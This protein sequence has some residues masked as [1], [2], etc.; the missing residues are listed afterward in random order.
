MDEDLLTF[1]G[2]GRLRKIDPRDRQY[3]LPPG[4]AV[5]QPTAKAYQHWPA[6]RALDQGNSSSCVG[7]ACHALLRCSP[8]RNSKNIPD[9]YEIY[10]AAQLIDEWPGIEYDGT[11]VRA[12]VRVLQKQGYI[13]SYRWAF[14]GATAVNHILNVGP[15]VI[16]VDYYEGM[17]A[18]D[19]KGFVYPKGRMIGGHAVTVIGC[20]TL[21]KCPDGNTG[22]ITYLNSWSESWGRKGRAKLSMQAFDQLIRANGEAAAVFEVYKPVAVPA[23]S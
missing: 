19:K 1:P 17:M 10:N 11:S 5:D 15:V 2:G 3:M 18:V 6:P 16:G 13:S 23:T 20:N 22:S 8:I 12:G 21:E 14:D 7:H 9:P 4:A